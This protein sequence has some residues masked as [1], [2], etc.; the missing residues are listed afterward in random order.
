MSLHLCYDYV[1]NV[2]LCFWGT[3][4]LRK[5]VLLHLF[6]IDYWYIFGLILFIFLRDFSCWLEEKQ[7]SKEK[8][9][10]L[11]FQPQKPKLINFFFKELNNFFGLFLMTIVL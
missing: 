1:A 5:D 8:K 10:Q 9:T 2:I 3:E 6:Y 7:R 4:R 11:Y